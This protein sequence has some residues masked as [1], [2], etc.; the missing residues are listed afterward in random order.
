MINNR[1]SLTA[2]QLANLGVNPD[3]LEHALLDEQSLAAAKWVILRRK[4]N[5][6]NQMKDSSYDCMFHPGAYSIQERNILRSH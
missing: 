2:Q 4:L 5:Y 6:L 3:G 1:V